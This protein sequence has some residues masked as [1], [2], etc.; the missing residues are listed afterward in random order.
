[1]NWQQNTG[2]PAEY[3][4]GMMREMNNRWGN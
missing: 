1:M 4:E 2:K 3:T